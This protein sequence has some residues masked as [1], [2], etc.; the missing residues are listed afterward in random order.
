MW[1]KRFSWGNE[2]VGET[3]HHVNVYEVL[4]NYAE[5]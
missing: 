4:R 1:G 5:E 3:I 2:K